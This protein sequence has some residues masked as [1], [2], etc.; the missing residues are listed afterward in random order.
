VL[1]LR[2]KV[3]QKKHKIEVL[4]SQR[5]FFHES[6]IRP[7]YLQPSSYRCCFGKTL[8][9]KA[10]NEKTKGWITSSIP[11]FVFMSVAKVWLHSG[12]VPDVI[13][14]ILPAK[15]T[16]RSP[17]SVNKKNLQRVDKFVIEIVESS[18]YGS[19]LRED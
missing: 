4:P 13:L 17:N 14:Q 12:V 19:F 6:Q 3:S 5:F 9:N 18:R 7:F 1:Y 10:L 16:I 15:R 11:V 8:E 2:E